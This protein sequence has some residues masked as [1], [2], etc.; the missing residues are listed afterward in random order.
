MANEKA[1]FKDVYGLIRGC[2]K[3]PAGIYRI[4]GYVQGQ[5]ASIQIYKGDEQ[6][7]VLRG[8]EPVAALSFTESKQVKIYCISPKAYT[9]WNICDVVAVDTQ[10][11]KFFQETIHFSEVNR[12]F[13]AET[14]M[15]CIGVKED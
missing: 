10:V 2:L 4:P 3:T 1:T 8:N 15:R 12:E 7:V 9:D 14:L 11:S 13:L 6:A 5:P